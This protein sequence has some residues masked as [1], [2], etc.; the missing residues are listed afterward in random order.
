MNPNSSPASDSNAS[1]LNPMKLLAPSDDDPETFPELVQPLA[2]FIDEAI[3]GK[4]GTEVWAHL[5][6][7]FSH[8]E[9]H[10]YILLPSDDATGKLSRII[11]TLLRLSDSHGRVLNQFEHDPRGLRYPIQF[12]FVKHVSGVRPDEN[13]SFLWCIGDNA[14][15]EFSNPPDPNTSSKTDQAI[16]EECRYSIPGVRGQIARLIEH[17][18]TEANWDQLTEA[19]RAGF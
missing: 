14:G 7:R 10:A 11:A 6:E 17:L 9:N 12:T 4:G 5:N 19:Q 18:S 8:D 16:Y 3:G 13:C 15:F 2:D 1:L